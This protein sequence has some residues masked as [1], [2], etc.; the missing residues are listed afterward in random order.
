MWTAKEFLKFLAMIT[1]MVLSYLYMLKI[2]QDTISEVEKYLGLQYEGNTIVACDLV[3]G[4]YHLSN[5]EKVST[6]IIYNYVKENYVE[7]EGQFWAKT[8]TIEFK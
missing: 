8:V 7:Y 5:G 6:E 2:S 3:W 1:F 4:E